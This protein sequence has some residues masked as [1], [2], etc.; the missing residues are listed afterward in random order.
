MG[1]LNNLIRLIR[2]FQWYKNLIIFVPAIFSMLIFEKSIFLLTLLGFVSLCLASSANYIINDIID[3]DVDRLHPEKKKRP[4]A[5]RAIPI[6]IASLVAVLFLLGAFA[7]GY[8]LSIAF[9]LILLFF[10]LLTQAYSIW[11]KHLVFVDVLTI[12]VNFVTRA[13]AGL[14]FLHK[15][16]TPWLILCPFF[17]ALF[18]AI[19]KRYSDLKF[20]GTNAA[21]HRKVLSQ[22]TPEL[23]NS[24]L[25]VS[26]ALL[27]ISYSLYA[28]LSG[29]QFYL[30]LSLPFA[31]YLIF[32][33]FSL[34]HSDSD[35][36]RH[37]EKALK[38]THIIIGILLWGIFTAIAIYYPAISPIVSGFFSLP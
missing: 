9:A 19:G 10:V 1:A 27:I 15:S 30:M 21:G 36:P 25:I 4:I 29:Q 28:F 6:W 7:I 5:S 38:D 12:S 17:L 24:L 23:A 26:T 37:P 31:L 2:P 35:I 22:Y 32:Y 11:L 8:S 20:L 34:L 18:L 16:T 33:Y 3:R 13:V 14:L